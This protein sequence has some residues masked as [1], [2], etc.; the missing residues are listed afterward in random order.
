[1]KIKPVACGLAAVLVASLP[2]WAGLTPEAWA[3]TKP[4]ADT[5]PE[6]PA[7]L[8]VRARGAWSPTVN[9][10]LDDLVTSRGSAWRAKRAN[11]N[12]VPGSTS[13]STALD[14]ER[15]A[16]GFNPGGAWVGSKT[17]HR[18]DLVLRLGS[19]W[20]ALRTNLNV[21]PG[22]SPADWQQFAAKG[23]PG[24]NS[25]GNGSVGAPSISFASDPSTGIF[26]PET[27]K[28]A[29]SAGGTLFLHNIGTA[30]TALGAGALDSNTTGSNNTAM[31]SNALTANTEGFSNTAVGMSALENNSTG[32]FNTALGKGVL[33]A[34]S[35][36]FF[37]TAVGVSAL[38]ANTLGNRNIAVGSNALISNTTGASNVAVGAE[39]LFTNIIGGTNTAVGQSAL[40]DNLGNANTAVGTNALLHN[41]D[42]NDNTAVGRNALSANTTGASNTVIGRGALSANTTGASNIALGFN[43]GNTATNPSNSI[44]IGNSGLAADTATIKIG[45][46]GTQTTAFMAGIV[47]QPAPAGITVFIDA[48]TGQLGTLLS[49]RRYKEDIQPMADASAALRKLRPVTFRYSKPHADGS[50]PI[51]YGLIAEEV[52][53]FLPDLAVFNKDGAP[54]TVK[55]HLLPSLLLNEVQGQQ[56]T[57]ERQE[58]TIRSQ[59]E[60]I[61][62]LERRLNSLEA[63]VSRPGSAAGIRR[64]SLIR[65]AP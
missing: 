61:A 47:G 16:A 45:T 34:N 8:L 28:I 18:D 38:A 60:Q 23:A 56:R 52:A 17:Y 12:K 22:I 43:A 25:V 53:E 39:A 3:Q 6:A 7:P 19:T 63:A 33:S 57:I 41:T 26:S 65:T 58:Q 1:M 20:R 4:A 36:G 35:T 5:A 59:A 42:G 31:G 48:V 40:Q 9:Y 49:S 44:F 11:I 51:Q 13:P 55:Y 62:A 15:F 37:N 46:Q 50:K 64:A 24:G 54:E 2:L 14:W 30:T 32:V 10:V 27:G 21:T 29:M